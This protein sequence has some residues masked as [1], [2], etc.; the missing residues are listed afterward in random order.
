LTE[1]NTEKVATTFFCCLGIPLAIIRLYEPFVWNHFKQDLLSL[2]RNKD[3]GKEK[4]KFSNVPLCAF[5]NSA[6]NI[7]FVYLILFGITRF[8][9]NKISRSDTE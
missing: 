8:N 6:M 5:A 4:K 1:L 7:E 9:E 3:V 2:S